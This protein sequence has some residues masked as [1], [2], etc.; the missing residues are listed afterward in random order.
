MHGVAEGKY[1]SFVVCPPRVIISPYSYYFLAIVIQDYKSASSVTILGATIK[2]DV[3]VGSFDK[4][5]RAGR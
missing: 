1:P 3:N 4:R 2:L 5:A